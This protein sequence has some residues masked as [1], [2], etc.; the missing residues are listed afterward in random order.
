MSARFAG[1]GAALI[2]VL[3]FL[4]PTPAAAAPPEL[5]D[6]IAAAW[7][8]DR[9]YIY[10]AM[11]PALPKAEL[12]RIRAATRTVDFPVYVALVPR[13]PY[14][15]RDAG[16][17]CRRC[18]RPVSVSRGCIWCPRSRTTTGRAPRS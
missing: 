16:A 8:T 10:D 7:K 17:I 5:P 2:A 12:D 9:I 11:R 14:D 4:S 1:L 3:A 13:V 18:C 6:Q 15:A